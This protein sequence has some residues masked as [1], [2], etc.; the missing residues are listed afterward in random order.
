MTAGQANRDT[1]GSADAQK[2]N[3]TRGKV[4]VLETDLVADNPGLL[5]RYGIVHSP[6]ILDP[7]LVNPWGIAEGPTSP[8]WV[9]DNGAGVSTLYNVPG[10]NAP[11]GMVPRVFSIPAPGDP[12]NRTGTPTGAVFNTDASGQGFSVVG[13][14]R[15]NNPAAAPAFFLFATEDGTI[16]GWNPNINPSGFDPSLVGTYGIIAVDNSTKPTAADGAVYKGLAI[17]TDTG[18]HTFLYATNFR[19]GTVEVYDTSFKPVR[20]PRDAFV[21]PHLPHGYAPF[22]V[23]LAAG[24]LFVT[25]AK[26]DREKHDDVARPGHG[27]VDVFDLRGRMLARFAQHGH[28]NS[29]WGLV[30]APPSFG[31]FAG[32]ILIGNFGDGRIHAFDPRNGRFIGRVTNSLGQ[33]I[34]IDGL[35]SLTTGNG[36]AGGEAGTIYFTA[37]PNGEKDGLFGSLTPVELGTPC[38]IPCR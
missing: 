14:D 34:L 1:T 13:V 21:D 22:N 26:Q 9:A 29:P 18:G 5:D 10:G 16:A 38:G 8:F 33:D 2:Q 28:L 17:A 27:I 35:W 37:G 4:V 20:L 32:A 12:L 3:D 25:Y 30:Q 24:R 6:F 23:V 19:A 11:V 36:G 15:N 7:H 31:E